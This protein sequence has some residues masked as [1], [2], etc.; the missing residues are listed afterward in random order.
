MEPGSQIENV[1]EFN[2]KHKLNSELD[3]LTK[4][5]GL[6]VFVNIND[7][8]I[9]DRIHILKTMVESAP[10]KK[11]TLQQQKDDLF[12]DIDKAT[13]KKP[14]NRLF[15]IH[16]SIKLKEYLIENIDNEEMRSELTQKLCKLAEEG[17]INSKKFVTYNPTLEKI[18]AIPCLN[19]K[20]NEYK[21]NL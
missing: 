1:R 21:I 7:V 14:W 9:D 6:K 16:K 19:V 4:G 18:E 10:A 20:D 12:K 2:L 13:F 15:H 17:K 8:N 5:E 11:D 3:Y